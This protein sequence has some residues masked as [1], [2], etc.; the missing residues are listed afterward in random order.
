M[1]SN[2]KDTDFA[3]INVDVSDRI[4]VSSKK[5]PAPKQS[6]SGT[7][8]PKGLLV[9]A[10][11]IALGASGGCAYLYSELQKSQ[12]T[13]VAN[14][15]RIQSLENRLSATGEEMGNSTVALQVK[16]SELTEKSDELWDQMDKLWASAWR[17][18]QEE[19]K[20]VNSDVVALQ[21]KLTSSV[22][23]VTK[24]VNDAQSGNQQLMSRID[25]LNSKITEQANNL[26]AVKDEYESVTDASST[27]N[28]DIRDLK[29]KV[30]LLEKRNTSL[31]QK[32]NQVEGQVK[33]LTVKTI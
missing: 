23:D 7:G 24:K 3:P 20:S 5:S 27:Q 33:E 1:S 28:G 6:G 2:S 19:I 8:A 11:L 10:L 22:S 15:N 9:V 32:L 25:S 29:E 16:V 31:L 4:P 14:Q 18:N 26:L 13:I 30:L 12:E 21:S 17:R